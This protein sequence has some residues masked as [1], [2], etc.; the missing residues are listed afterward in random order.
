MRR[1]SGSRHAESSALV[2]L[3]HAD[4]AGRDTR[5]T[6]HHPLL[7]VATVTRRDVAVVLRLAVIL[8]LRL[9]VAEYGI[10]DPP[11]WPLGT[12]GWGHDTQLGQ[13]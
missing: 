12:D 4:R 3:P 6:N 10:Q 5:L 11:T 7:G 13:M 9:G 2:R 1:Y 8:V